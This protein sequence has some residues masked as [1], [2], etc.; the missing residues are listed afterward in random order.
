MASKKLT[1]ISDIH[2]NLEAFK[3]VLSD[4]DRLG[5]ETVVCLGDNIGYGPEPDQVL[6][7]LRSRNIPSLMGNHEWGL[8]DERG[9]DWFNPQA[10]RS[11]LQN[12]QLLSEE[13]VDY[14]KSLPVN[15]LIDDCLLVHACPPDSIKTYLFEISPAQFSQIFLEMTNDICMVGHTHELMI[16]S[17]S[18][19]QITIAPLTEGI[20]TLDQ[21]CKYIVNVGSVGQ[22][23]DGNNNAK[24]VIWDSEKRTLEVRFVPYNIR[25]TA[26]KIMALG[27]PR[28]NADRL[29]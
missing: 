24:Y 10:R 15:M 20:R 2:G 18:A 25:K 26:E 11:L 5:L 22:P 1:V 29:W 3:A 4:I 9:L 12:R 27:L 19:G 21:K 13:S 28:I 6:A 14:I 8:L 16:I 7:L 17:F 23:R